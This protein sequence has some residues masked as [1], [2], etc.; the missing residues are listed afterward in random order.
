M[1]E[2]MYCKKCGQKLNE[3]A[4]FCGNCGAP[5]TAQS[6]PDMTVSIQGNVVSSNGSMES[7]K[8]KK[9]EKF[10]LPVIIIVVVALIG[11]GVWFAVYIL[12][13]DRA[14]EIR[15]RKEDEIG[16]E[17][18]EREEDVLRTEAGESG[19]DVTAESNGAEDDGTGVEGE[20]LKDD[21]SDLAD[22]ES[23]NAAGRDETGIHTYEL[24]VEDVT[25]TEAYQKC[26][27]KGGYLVRINSEEEYQAI[28]QQINAEDKRNIKFWLG[29][30]RTAESPDDYRWV[31]EDGTLGDII[32]N[33]EEPYLSYWLSGEPSYFGEDK[34]MAEMF[35]NMFYVS[36]EDRWV[37]NDVTNDILAVVNYYSG[38]IGYICEYEDN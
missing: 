28:L 25:W 8:D 29:G 2:K 23:S 6:R 3:G 33:E 13:E 16:I 24:V 32:L 12:G 4:V 36:K 1:K 38:T 31:Y 20:E 17:A 37:W 10:I 18:P 34:N 21:I 7:R 14:D 19:E 35:M 15:S 27:E 5:V 22:T 26:L 11:A 9:A 30:A